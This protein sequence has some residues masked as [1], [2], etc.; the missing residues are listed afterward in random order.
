MR[1]YIALKTFLFASAATA[2]IASAGSA[3]AD[4][5]A[6]VETVVVTAERRAEPIFD[7]P[8]TVTAISGD[9]LNNLG[10]TDMKS[11]VAMVPNAVLP[12]D[13]E[14]FETYINIRGVHQADINAEPNFGL[15]RNGM[16]AGGERANIGAQI[17]ISRIEVLSGPQSGLY[18]RDAVGGVVN[19]I[20]NTATTDTNS[21]YFIASVGRYARTELQGAANIPLANNFAIRTTGWWINQQEGQ[22][23]NSYLNQYIDQSR[24]W[25][26]RLS[27]RWD[28][29][30]NLSV[31][32]M[33]EF[34]DKHGPSFTGFI[35]KPFGASFGVICCGLLSQPA[36]TMST[37][38]N[39][40]PD[41]E[42]WQQV[43]LSQD[44]NYDTQSWAG[45]F[46]LL[47]AYRD[48]HLAEQEDWDHT[49]IAPTAGPMV[50][51]QI[52]YRNEGMHNVYGELVWRSPEN[53]PLTWIAGADYFDE[54]FRFTRIFAGSVDF[55]LLNLPAFGPGYT[56]ANLLCSFLMPG[57]NGGFFGGCD[58]TPPP[59]ALPGLPGVPLGGT[60]PY[61]VPNLGV[62]S[63]ANA[64]GGPGSGIDTQSEAAFASLT[65]K[66][67]SALSVRADVRWDQTRKSLSYVQGS[68]PGYGATPAGSAY[69]IPLF[70]GVFVPYTSDQADTYVNVAPSVTV[71][72]KFSDTANAYATYATGFRS[73][74]F[75]LGTSTPAY[76]PYKPEKDANYEIGAKTLWLDGT[77]GVNADIFYMTQSNLVE[78][79]NDLSEPAFLY[80]YYLANVGEARTYGAELSAAY[81]AEHWL[82]L[83]GS[84]GWLDDRITKGVAQGWSVVG[85][86]IPLTRKW[87]INL[88]ADV[89]YPLSSAMDLVGNVNYRLEYGGF[90]PASQAAGHYVLETTPYSSLNKLDLDLG[91]A[92]GQTRI[93][94]FVDNAL[95]DIIPQFQYANGAIN[96]NEGRTYGLRLEQKF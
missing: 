72:Y 3:L 96:V 39:D 77:L 82:V 34:E 91:I 89:D 62:Q 67:T 24:D 61:T 41:T 63:S 49:A 4:E 81:Q 60:Y 35:P 55:N 54:T 21:G 19:V 94:A 48:Y 23:Y 68:V 33:A 56:Y 79:E 28:A 80:L 69:L 46:E 74:S 42:Q 5:T 7:V 87:T 45:S 6:G 38:Q 92:M 73:G 10:I 86:Q 9:D 37:I 32:W 90:L 50:V 88:T 27:A 65:Y 85:Q 64:F 51:Q 78:P 36:Q 71:Q 12:D 18:G 31:V 93:V 58:G 13:P 53:Q 14:N 44:V 57:F 76:L 70:A 29:M 83:G 95:N 59:H 47:A 40:T 8:A 84:M 17:D 20:Y 25:G 2:L 1:N 66:L 11:V 75:N 30:P 15:Y 22:L 52:Q 16:F 26:A 43:Y